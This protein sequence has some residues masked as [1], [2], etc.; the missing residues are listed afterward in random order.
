MAGEGGEGG[1]G[2]SGGSGGGAGAPPICLGDEDVRG[3]ADCGDLEYGADECTARAGN[4]PPLGMILCEHY[5]DA[6]TPE[7]FEAMFDCLDSLPEDAVSNVGVCSD[8]HDTAVNDCV[9]AIV[10]DTCESELAVEK[11]EAFGCLGEDLIDEEVCVAMLSA[12]DDAGVQA[13]IDCA[14]EVTETP[15][16]SPWG[17]SSDVV[18]C[19]EAFLNCYIGLGN[20]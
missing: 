13:V 7:A 19:D 2:G 20:D 6:A 16:G 10:F 1:T 14:N 5:A 12:Y 4:E 3:S 17:G 11:C 18:A 8:T 15:S 9:G